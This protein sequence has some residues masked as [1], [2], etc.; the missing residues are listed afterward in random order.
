M[1]CARNSVYLASVV[2][3]ACL[4]RYVILAYPW[5]TLF[6]CATFFPSCLMLCRGWGGGCLVFTEE[7]WVISQ[8]NSCGICGSQSGASTGFLRVLRFSLCQYL[9]TKASFFYFTNLSTYDMLYNLNNWQNI[10]CKKSRPP[11]FS[12]LSVSVLCHLSVFYN[13]M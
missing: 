9:F 10:Y 13:T 5:T 7:P 8:A 6:L 1:I 3:D 4:L 2:V 11:L 12:F